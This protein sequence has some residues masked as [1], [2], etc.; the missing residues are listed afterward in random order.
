MKICT[1]CASAAYQVAS[2]YDTS[3]AHTKPDIKGQLYY[4]NHIAYALL[5][6][7]YTPAHPQSALV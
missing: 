6:V 3:I 5:F 1:S 2:F 7:R 4:K